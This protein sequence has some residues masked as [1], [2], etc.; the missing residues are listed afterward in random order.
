MFNHDCKDKRQYSTI[1]DIRSCRAV[2][3]F[4]GKFWM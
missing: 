1:R 4:V 3:W 2:G